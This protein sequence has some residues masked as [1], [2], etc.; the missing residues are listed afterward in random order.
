M[1]RLLSWVVA[2]LLLI[3]GLAGAQ[4]PAPL[5]K[6]TEPAEVQLLDGSAI[7]MVILQQHIEVKTDYGLLNVPIKDVI[8]IDF[9]IHLPDGLEGKIAQAIEKLGDENYKVREAALKE[10]I[11]WGPQAYPQLVGA[12]KSDVN[13]VAKRVAMA[14]QKIRLKHAPDKLRL[15]FEDVVV[16]TKFTMA[17]RIMTPQVKARN[18]TIGELS[19]DLTRLRLIRW[20]VPS[21]ETIVTVDAAKHGS[22]PNQWMD[23]GFETQPGSAIQITASGSVDLRAGLGAGKGLFT[24]PKGYGAGGFGGPA[25]VMGDYRPG[26]LLGKI[27]EDGAP[28]VIGESHEITPTREGKLYLHIVPSHYGCD[29]AGTYKVKI[30]PRGEAGGPN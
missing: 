5:Q 2:C 1:C 26:C 3:V 12:A 25:G 29:S 9:G 30:A 21:I 11:D 13:E 8:K 18:E 19:L 4:P 27:G 10:L 24:T 15:R 7:R 28:F 16:T 17:G 6:S 23:A 14:L 22:A 20:T